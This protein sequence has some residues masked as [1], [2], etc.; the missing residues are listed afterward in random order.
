MN[1]VRLALLLLY[2]LPAVFFFA[3]FHAVGPKTGVVGAGVAPALFDDV[4]LDPLGQRVP[5]GQFVARRTRLHTPFRARSRQTIDY[6]QGNSSLPA[7]EVLD[8]FVFDQAGMD[9]FHAYWARTRGM[10]GNGEEV[11][12]CG[13]LSSALAVEG[14]EADVKYVLPRPRHS[15]AD[16][17]LSLDL[18]YVYDNTA[19]GSRAREGVYI[20]PLDLEITRGKSGLL[21][22]V[23]MSCLAASLV[24]FYVVTSKSG[25][26]YVDIETV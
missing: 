22:T 10:S 7:S 13:P 16:S 19:F 20:S 11:A 26:G 6:I 25:A 9:C 14:H 8:L 21:D 1:T 23:L 18:F 3:R 5:V 17:L 24:T 12:Y 2:V 15:D 4:E